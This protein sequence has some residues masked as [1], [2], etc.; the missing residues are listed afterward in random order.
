MTTFTFRISPAMAEILNS[1]QLRAWL[2]EFLRHPHQ[3][4][5]DP[6]PGSARI[7][8]TL[9]AYAVQRAAEYLRCSPSEALRRVAQGAIQSRPVCDGEKLVPMTTDEIGQMVILAFIPLLAL[10]VWIFLILGRAKTIKEHDSQRKCDH[11]TKRASSRCSP[12]GRVHSV[13]GL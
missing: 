3:L 4:P 9:H 2:A 10:T 11:T 13:T 7:S 1:A 12:G 8:L 6:G 5:R